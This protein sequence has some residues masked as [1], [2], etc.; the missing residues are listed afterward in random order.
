MPVIAALPTVHFVIGLRE[1]VEAALIVGIIATFLHQQGRADAIR[2]MWAGVALAIALCLGVAVVLQLIDQDLP[3]RQQE[4]FEAV[5]G[6]VAVGMVT[7]MIVFMRRHAR[8]LGGELRNSAASALAAGSAWGLV[9]MAFLAVM[10]EGLETA[11][12]LLAA[13]QASVGVSPVVAGLGAVSG[14][15]VAALIGWLIYR[16]GMKVN[17]S[18]FFRVTAVLLV[19]I[20]AGLVS[21]AIHHA[22]EAGLFTSFSGRALDLS[23]IVVP[24]S[25]SITTG[26]ITGLLGVYPFPT[27]AE[28]AG[29]LLYAVPMLVYVLWPQGRSLRRR[30]DDAVASAA[31]PAGRGVA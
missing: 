13:F 11:V 23:A 4:A 1:G 16:S 5:V 24:R 9:A 14:V 6:L 29:W 18:R 25:D 21:S 22:D 12:F 27:T 2:W 3:D 10:R 30:R 7:F 17:L 26:L 15:L 28:V 20:A 31:R 8:Q 19:I